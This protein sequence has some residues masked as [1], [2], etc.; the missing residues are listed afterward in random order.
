VGL[1][2]VVGLPLGFDLSAEVVPLGEQRVTLG[3]GYSF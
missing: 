1:G 3:V 2:A